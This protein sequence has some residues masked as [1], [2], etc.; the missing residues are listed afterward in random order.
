MTAEVHSLQNEKQ[1]NSV[2]AEVHSLQHEKRFDVYPPSS[3]S[4]CHWQMK[5]LLMLTND[6]T[7]ARSLSGMGLENL[8][9]KAAVD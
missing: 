8:H 4:T 2:T 1:K 6:E 9:F 3:K 7:G 5:A